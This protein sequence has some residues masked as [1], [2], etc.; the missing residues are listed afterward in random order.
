MLRRALMNSHISSDVSSAYTWSP[1]KTTGSGQGSTSL[2]MWRAYA[3]MASTPCSRLPAASWG[4][5]V[6]H[7]PKVKR[8][9]ASGFNVAIR[10]GGYGDPGG[11]HTGSP[12]TETVYS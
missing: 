11:G 12:P 5:L 9:S 3:R 2:A 4:T 10:L 8:K 7:D 1:R 6:R